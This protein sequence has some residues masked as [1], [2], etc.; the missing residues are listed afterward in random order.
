MHSEYNKGKLPTTV[1]INLKEEREAIDFSQEQLS[2]LVW[3]GSDGLAR[4]RRLRSH[5]SNDPILKNDH[6]SYEMTRE[7]IMSLQ[8]QKMARVYS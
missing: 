1:N 5:F 8:Y 4:F 7:E 3:G 6:F 2:N